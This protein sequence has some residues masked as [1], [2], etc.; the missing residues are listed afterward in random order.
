MFIIFFAPAVGILQAIDLKNYLD[1]KG[2]RSARTAVFRLLII[3]GGWLSA[4]VAGGVGLMVVVSAIAGAKSMGV[5]RAGVASVLGLGFLGLAAFLVILPFRRAAGATERETRKRREEYEERMAHPD[6]AGIEEM[7]GWK[8]PVQY[9]SLFAEKSE[10][11][12]RSWMLYPDGIEKDERLYDVLGLVPAH[13]D[14]FRPC[15][16]ASQHYVAFARGEY[17]EYWFEL[18]PD[19]PPVYLQSTE[20]D[21]PAEERFTRIAERL[22][23]FLSWPKEEL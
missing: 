19:D 7:C 17:C 18:G 20:A 22:S 10:W 6:F 2:D 4:A 3:L 14:A 12:G 23:E 8:L 11:K 15:G 21:S 9:Q 1:W 16:G 13:P 5:V